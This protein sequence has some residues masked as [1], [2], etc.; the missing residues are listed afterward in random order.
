[1][2]ESAQMNTETKQPKSVLQQIK[3][4]LADNDTIVVAEFAK[5]SGVPRNQISTAL[6]NLQKLGKI[7]RAHV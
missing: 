3:E 4:Y 7:G 5:A 6:W 2:K 1:M